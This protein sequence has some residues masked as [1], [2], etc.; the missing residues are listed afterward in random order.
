MI[1]WVDL[2]GCA[3]G[4]HLTSSPN[5]WPKRSAMWNVAF[6][7]STGTSD[8][9][10]PSTPRAILQFHR[11]WHRLPGKHREILWA[12]Y[13]A[14]TSQSQQH[15]KYQDRLHAAHKAIIKM[16]IELDEE[17]NA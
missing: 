8:I 16:L 5:G 1:G 13:V 6:Q 12:Q 2:L 10:V 7:T 17:V 9:S 3:W 15:C 4:R 14:R 11:A